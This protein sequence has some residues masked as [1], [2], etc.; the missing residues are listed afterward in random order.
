M[1]KASTFL[2]FIQAASVGVLAFQWSSLQGSFL[3]LKGGVLRSSSLQNTN[4]DGYWVRKGRS[5]AALSAQERE[6]AEKEERKGLQLVLLYMTP[7][8]NPNSIFVYLFLILYV[9]GKMSEA[10]MQ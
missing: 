6:E 10:R 1:R 7:W 8:R 3:S 9:L 4:R 5:L 2:L